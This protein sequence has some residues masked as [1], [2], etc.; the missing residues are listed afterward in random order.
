MES[1]A[2]YYA[3]IRINDNNKTYSISAVSC[4]ESNSTQMENFCSELAEYLVS[5]RLGDIAWYITNIIK[6]AMRFDDN[7]FIACGN[8]LCF[9]MEFDHTIDDMLVTY[10]LMLKPCVNDSTVLNLSIIPLPFADERQLY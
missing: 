2:N 9:Y 4:A 7:H 3:R 10:R 5:V 6:Y 8:E 1:F